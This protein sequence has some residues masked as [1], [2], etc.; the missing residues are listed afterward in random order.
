M[1]M[2][3]SRGFVEEDSKRMYARAMLW[4]KEKLHHE[5]HLLKRNVNSLNDENMRLRTT[6]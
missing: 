5:S 3:G 2:N 4:D 1:Y 6:I